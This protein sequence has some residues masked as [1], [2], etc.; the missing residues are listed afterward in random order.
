V[1]AEVPTSPFSINHLLNPVTPQKRS[2]ED[3]EEV[4]LEC[5]ESEYSSLFDSFIDDTAISHI[6]TSETKPIVDCPSL[7]H[8]LG[9]LSCAFDLAQ[10]AKLFRSPKIG[11]VTSAQLLEVAGENMDGL[12][13]QVSETLGFGPTEMLR[14]GL[15]KRLKK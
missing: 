1:Q 2:R 14:I 6:A 11:I 12:I 8:F 4:E 13:G 3:E 7:E 5:S 10:H 9:S 15:Q